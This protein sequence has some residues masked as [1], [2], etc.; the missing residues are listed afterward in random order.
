LSRYQKHFVLPSWDPRADACWFALPIVVRD[1]DQFTRNDLIRW[2]EGKKIE[3][4]FLLAGNIVRQ[5]G[6]TSIRH[7][8]VGNL[9]NTDLVMRGGFFVGVYPGLDMPRLDYMLQQFEAFFEERGIP[10]S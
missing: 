8:T 9:T 4:R 7:R 6:Y 3:T 2:L 10:Y 5:P 1:N